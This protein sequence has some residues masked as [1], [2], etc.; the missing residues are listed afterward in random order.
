VAHIYLIAGEA[1]GDQIGA[2]LISALRKKNPTLKISG[3]GGP[4]MTQ[5]GLKSLFPM[6]ELSVMG[7][8][9]ILPHLPVVLKRLRETE[10]H[11][12][13]QQPD[14]IVTIDS[15][16]FNFRIAKRLKKRG[17]PVVHYTAPSVWA[18]RPGRAKK[19]AKFLSHLLTLFPFE[20]PYFEKEGLPTTFVGHPLIE[21][22]IPSSRPQSS[23]R[24]Q[25]GYK[26]TQPLLCLLPGSRKKE[27]DTLLP[28]FLKALEKIKLYQPDLGIIL[29]TLPYLEPSLKIYL[30]NSDLPI[31]VISDPQEKFS[32][33]AASDIALAASGTVSLELALTQTPMVIAY[34]I[35]F[36]TAY[37][38]RRLL[39]T[40]YV[41]LVNILLNEPL[42]PELLQEN[43]TVENIVES[44][45]KEMK[46]IQHNRLPEIRD[47]LSSPLGEPSTLAAEQILTFIKH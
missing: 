25:Y 35:N 27:I 33:M 28:L 23:F 29:P 18:W 12:L 1:S 39:L 20:P 34:K 14:V 2:R 30:N 4:Q 5:Q 46:G 10:K 11:I 9:E 47:L 41:C 8:I 31:K 21:M 36:L 15:P 13:Q 37:L 3:V 22:K 24:A 45:S 26:D 6:E 38:M 16:G 44:I 42:V 32:A 40:P 7:L 17:I 43:C 19:V